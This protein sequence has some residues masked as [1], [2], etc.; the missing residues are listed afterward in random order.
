MTN[1]TDY[2]SANYDA[3][4]VERQFWSA[5]NE[6]REARNA[7]ERA[8]GAPA[9]SG[10]SSISRDVIQ[11]IEIATASVRLSIIDLLL[12]EGGSDGN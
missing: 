5:L 8:S 11:C 2:Y 12:E 4:F 9:F 6:F 10:T 3:I 7:F 1:K